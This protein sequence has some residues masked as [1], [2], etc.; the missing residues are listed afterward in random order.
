MKTKAP[1]IIRG[2]FWKDG[3]RVVGEQMAFVFTFAKKVVRSVARGFVWIR[4][5]GKQIRAANL[6]ALFHKIMD[7]DG[8]LLSPVLTAAEKLKYR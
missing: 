2:L 7:Y 6:R 1:K 3:A 5:D 4:P 8:H